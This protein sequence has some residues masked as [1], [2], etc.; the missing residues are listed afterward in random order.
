MWNTTDK[1]INHKTGLLNLAKERGNAS[2][3]CQAMGM[4]R[5]PLSPRLEM[6]GIVKL[7]DDT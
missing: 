4:S 2:K 1:I 3:T 6:R 5:D 7:H